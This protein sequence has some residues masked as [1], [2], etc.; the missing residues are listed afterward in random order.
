MSARTAAALVPEFGREIGLV[1][2]SGDIA[3]GTRP[4]AWISGEEQQVWQQLRDGEGVIISEPLVIKENLS[5]PPEPITLLTNEG[6]REFPVLAV[7]YDYASDQGTIWIGS[8]IYGELWDDTAVS[9]IAMFVDEGVD[10]DQTVAEMKAHFA[11]RQ[12]LTIQSNQALR[13]NTV[14][15]WGK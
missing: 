4:Y 8:E 1:A 7:F 12:E 11:G 13:Q 14:A 3:D 9:T 6:E 15:R 10:V 5:I 2:V